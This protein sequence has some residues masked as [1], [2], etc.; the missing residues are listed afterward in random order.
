MPA[1]L[2]AV[3]VAGAE[4]AEMREQ[5]EGA[6]DRVILVTDDRF[7][8]GADGRDD[9]DAIRVFKAAV[10]RMAGGL[11]MGFCCLQVVA[12]VETPSHSTRRFD[13]D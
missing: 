12:R 2:D 6:T 8:F 11:E 3:L 10:A 13:S 1:G 7:V 5:R 9:A 4:L